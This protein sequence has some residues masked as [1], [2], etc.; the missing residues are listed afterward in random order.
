MCSCLTVFFQ[1][2]SYH[3]HYRSS[4]PRYGSSDDQLLIE[5]PHLSKQGM[6]SDCGLYWDQIAACI[7]IR[8]RPVLGSDCGLYWDQI[9]ACIGIRLRPVLGSDCGLYWDP[10]AACIGIRLRPVLGSD[11]GLYWDPIAACMPSPT[12]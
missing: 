2:V 3:L 12:C 10:I 4:L 1:A 9:V 8:L 5:V 7:G 6:G 11:C